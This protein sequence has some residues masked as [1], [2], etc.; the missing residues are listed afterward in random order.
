MNPSTNKFVDSSLGAM[1]AH[2]MLPGLRKF[3]LVCM[4]NILRINKFAL[5]RL[6]V[7]TKMS[8][9]EMKLFVITQFTKNVVK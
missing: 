5:S 1:L 4:L 2:N 8:H 9:M 3:K 7:A 6:I